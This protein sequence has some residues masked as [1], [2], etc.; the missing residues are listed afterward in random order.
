MQ[1]EYSS[2]T[3][4]KPATLYFALDS[5]G[6][7]VLADQ[8]S[9][10]RRSVSRAALH[11]AHNNSDDAAATPTPDPDRQTVWSKVLNFILE[12]LSIGGVSLSPVDDFL[13]D[14][15]W[16][17]AKHRPQEI[18]SPSGERL[19]G[20]FPVPSPEAMPHWNWWAS[21]REV[22]TA[23]GEH[24]RKE[25]D[26]RRAVDALSELDD[27]T[28]QDIGIPHRSRIEYVVRFCHDC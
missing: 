9:T 14:E 27:E 11:L 4:L 23:L 8:H 25:G 28:L 15:R 10:V 12:G 5:E 16:S 18:I 13:D 17:V 3:L 22:A 1:Q 7:A 26:I 24:L 21:S 19:I 2:E 6:T 20:M